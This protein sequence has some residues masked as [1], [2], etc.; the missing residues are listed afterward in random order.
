MSYPTTSSKVLVVVQT[1]YQHV[2]LTWSNLQR[3]WRLYIICTTKT[4]IPLLY[5]KMKQ[6]SVHFMCCFISVPIASK[7]FICILIFAVTFIIIFCLRCSLKPYLNLLNVVFSDLR[8]NRFLY[9]FVTCLL[10]LLS[11]RKCVLHGKFWD[12]FG[13]AIINSS[14]VLSQMRHPICSSALLSLTST[15]FE[16]W[17]YHV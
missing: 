17:L 16:Y 5:M 1:Y 12:S 2:T 13:W 15:R 7:R 9:G 4:E 8:G 10:S 14:F 6:S 3:L 11:L